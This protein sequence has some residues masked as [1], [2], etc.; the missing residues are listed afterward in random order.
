MRKSYPRA[1]QCPIGSVIEP[2]DVDFIDENGIRRRHIE[3][4]DLATVQSN[5]PRPCDYT[6]DKLL[7]AG[8]PLSE[9]PV[10]GLLNNS[11]KLEESAVNRVLHVI[12]GMLSNEKKEKKE[13]LKNGESGDNQVAD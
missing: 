13:E 6:L 11:S 5:I 8:V 1:S 7:K 4:V 2:R 3:Y 9:V 10:S 12:D